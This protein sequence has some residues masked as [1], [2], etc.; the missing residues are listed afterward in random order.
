MRDCLLVAAFVLATLAC[1]D[2]A[3]TTAPALTSGD[4]LMLQVATAS[5]PGS[6][7]AAP[8]R[9][10]G[11]RIEG[12][13]LMITLSHGGGCRPHNFGLFT[14]PDFGASNPPY[15]LFRLAHDSRGDQCDSDPVQG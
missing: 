8:A 12:H 4:D 1:S 5:P 6:L 7:P 9:I 14:G 15:A 13:H 10:E 2:G 11:A 3:E